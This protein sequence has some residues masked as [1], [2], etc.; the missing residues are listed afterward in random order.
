MWNDDFAGVWS[1]ANFTL[2]EASL[3]QEN[4]R[5]PVNHAWLER[6]WQDSANFWKGLHAYSDRRLGS[7]SKSTPFGRYD[8][9]HD[10]LARHKDQSQPALIWFEQEQWHTWTY[11]DVTQTVNALAATWEG[12]GVQP[13]EVLGILLPVGPQWLAALLA[14]LRL[15]LTVC[16]LPP[17]GNAFVQRR[18]TNLAPQWLAIDPLY[19]HQLAAEWQEL[20]LPDTLSSAAPVRRCHEYPGDGPAALCFDPINATID[21]PVAVNADT[22]YL[23]ALRDGSLGLGLKPG[24]LCAAPGWHLLES[25]PSLILAV[26]LSGACWVQIGLDDLVKAPERLLEQAIEV[27]GICRTLRDLLQANPPPGEKTWRYWFRHPAEAADYPLWQEFVEDF[28]LQDVFSGNLVWNAARGGILLFSTRSP[29]QPQLQVLPA[30]GLHW[31]LGILEAQELPHVEDWGQLALGTEKDGKTL[32]TATPYLLA[33]Y[34]KAWNYLGQYPQ[35][36]AGRTYPKQEILD[37]LAEKANYRALVETPIYN[38][39]DPRHV[40][41]VF[42]DNI[43]LKALENHIQTELGAEFLP[44]RIECIPLLPK[45]NKQGQADPDWC[46]LHYQTGGLYRRQRSA[47]FRYSTELKRLILR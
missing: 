6:S 31:Q 39:G 18:L 17:Q 15:G 10:L 23:S 22:L 42:G 19:R 35:G 8:F 14:G 11:A 47:V 2:I 12:T 45:R 30:A 36:R 43:D 5:R 46:Q 13:G 38:G 16:V 44:D 27:L 3:W 9:Y 34:R 26:L 25:Q 28:Q 24:Q 7:Q 21:S 37:V 4:Q 33:P 29:G 41:L 1:A 20:V 32:W 40:L